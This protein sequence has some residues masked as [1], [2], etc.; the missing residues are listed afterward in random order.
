MFKEDGLPPLAPPYSMAIEQ[1]ESRLEASYDYFADARSI[2]EIR[3][4]IRQIQKEGLHIKDPELNQTYT[5]DILF[6]N[7]EQGL[8]VITRYIS[9]PDHSLDGEGIEIILANSGVT[10]AGG[11]RNALVL[12]ANGYVVGRIVKESAPDSE[13]LP[14]YWTYDPY[15]GLFID[16][17]TGKSTSF[18]ELTDEQIR[19]LA[20]QISIGK[21][22]LERAAEEKIMQ[23]VSR[24]R[25]SS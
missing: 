2:T 16:P 6:D 21:H 20:V 5:G 7:L 24:I 1:P 13:S 14:D 25:R 12:A 10:E 9:E 4:R 18:N 19:K 11:L 3:S 8:F 15:I 23:N 17:S 22:R